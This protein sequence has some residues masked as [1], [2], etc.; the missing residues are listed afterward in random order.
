MVT[1]ITGLNSGLDVDSL[2]KKLM[3]A[4][5][6]PLNKLNQQSRRLNES[7]MLIGK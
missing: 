6:Q 2:V 5:K 3:D 4:E 7:A 1:R